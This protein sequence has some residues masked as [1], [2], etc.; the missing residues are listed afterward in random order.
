MYS[1]EQRRERYL[2]NRDSHLQACRDWNKN[3][4]EK[5]KGYQKKHRSTEAFKER[6]R[7]QRRADYALDSSK[8]KADGRK[9]RIGLRDTVIAHY[10]GKCACCG[11]ANKGFLT[12]D[13]IE[14][15]IPEMEAC[16]KKLGHWALYK[17]LIKN[18]FPPGYQLLCANCNMAIGWWGVCPHKQ[19][20]Y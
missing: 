20:P 17:Y 11:E 19:E 14:G 1:P 4:R 7:I 9:Y 8:E 12:V 2:D 13:H 5:C 6:R 18:N 10:G 16:G 15:V 3:N